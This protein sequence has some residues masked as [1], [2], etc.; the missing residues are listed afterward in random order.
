METN[1]FVKEDNSGNK[2][3]LRVLFKAKN[4]PSSA[5][6]HLKLKNENYSRM[7][8]S[9]DY[10]TKTFYC[11]RNSEKHYHNKMRGYGFNWSVLDDEHLDIQT[12]HL[13][14]DDT[15]NLVFTKELLNTHGKFLNFK[16]QGFEL[17]KFMPMEILRE[18]LK[19]YA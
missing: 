1:T 19:Q 12:I 17:Q 5:T 8:G 4:Q 16:Q 10:A 18:K 13:N 2:L 11:K 3:Y 7:I 14:I 6:I 15:E 9:Y